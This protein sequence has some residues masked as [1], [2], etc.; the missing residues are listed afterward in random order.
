[1]E[2]AKRPYAIYKRLPAKPKSGGKRRPAKAK[3]RPTF[4]VRFRDL[5]TS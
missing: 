5:D 2:R 1:M 3:S 4:Y